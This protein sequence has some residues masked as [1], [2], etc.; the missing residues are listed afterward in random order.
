MSLGRNVEVPEPRRHRLL[1]LSIAMLIVLA[2]FAG[3]G[4]FFGALWLRH[5]MRQS[6]PQLDGQV[7]LAGLTA[8]VTVRRD[9][10]GVPHIQAAGLDDLFM[11]QGY[12][13]AQDRLWQMDMARRF[14]SGNTASILG[15]AYI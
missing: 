12:V 8:V 3:A 9:Q 5:S 2:L 4:L 14:A 7:R 13:T 10:H 6:L 15:P 11:A 1:W